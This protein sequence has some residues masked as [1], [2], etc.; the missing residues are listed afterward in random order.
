M[1]SAMMWGIGGDMDEF[2]AMLA[3][4]DE[5]TLNIANELHTINGR[6]DSHS[7]KIRALEM[8]RNFVGGCTAVVVGI[9]GFKWK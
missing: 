2:H 3:R 4:I 8:W 9:L 6:L 7:S 5:R 1:R